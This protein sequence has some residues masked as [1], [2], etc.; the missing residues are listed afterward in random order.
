MK[1]KILALLLTL[2][3]VLLLTFSSPISAK[4]ESS[5]FN[6]GVNTELRNGARYY[7]YY[8]YSH[9]YKPHYY[10]WF[11]QWYRYIYRHGH[12]YWCR[13]IFH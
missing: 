1:K 12:G 8:G 9:W 2:V 5:P 3:T 7:C 10:Y 6:T 4:V 11:T 13:F